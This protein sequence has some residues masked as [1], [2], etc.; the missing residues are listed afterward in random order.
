MEKILISFLSGAI[1]VSDEEIEDAIDYSASSIPENVLKEAFD[2][3]QQ[4]IELISMS[5]FDLG[6]YVRNLLRKGGFDFGDVELDKN[7]EYLLWRAS[8]KIC[9]KKD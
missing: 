7:W 4:D 6:L 9:G 1:F 2:L 5:H 3:F 8:K